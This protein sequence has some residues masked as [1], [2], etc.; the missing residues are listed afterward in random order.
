MNFL[1]FFNEPEVLQEI[2]KWKFEGDRYKGGGW[3]F[4]EGPISKAWPKFWKSLNKWFFPAT[5]SSIKESIK[6]CDIIFVSRTGDEFW[7][8]FATLKPSKSGPKLLIGKTKA[9]FMIDKNLNVKIRR[10]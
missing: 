9:T 8:S 7:F 4:K 6:E 10:G 5:A 1:N 3:Q 2:I